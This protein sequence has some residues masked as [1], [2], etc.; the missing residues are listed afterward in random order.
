LA[1]VTLSPTESAACISCPR[2][3]D[4]QA[5]STATTS[6][7]VY[8]VHIIHLL[9]NIKTRIR[10][11]V[12]SSA[13]CS[14]LTALSQQLVTVGDGRLDGDETVPSWSPSLPLVLAG[15]PGSGARSLDG[16]QR[17]TQTYH[18]DGHLP[19][20]PARHTRRQHAR[21]S[22]LP[23][24]DPRSRRQ[25]YSRPGVHRSVSRLAESHQLHVLLQLIILLIRPI[26]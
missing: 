21:R 19:A 9:N 13:R 7:A 6:I 1:D 26:A 18:D 5:D 15:R 12:A 11:A 25:I 17:P 20:R 4:S 23:H 2:L 16:R 10:A 24:S 22:R 8:S 14:S 3:T